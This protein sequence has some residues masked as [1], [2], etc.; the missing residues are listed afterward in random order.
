MISCEYPHSHSTESP[1]ISHSYHHSY[2]IINIITIITI[3]T[4][5][6]TMK[7]ARKPAFLMNSM[8]F[9][10]VPS[11]P[12]EATEPRR[13]RGPPWPPDRCGT[14]GP[15]TSRDIGQS[16]EKTPTNCGNRMGIE[17]EESRDFQY[18][19]WGIVWI[20][21]QDGIILRKSLS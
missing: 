19:S 12:S 5:I 7:T 11:E 4:S 1:F 13:S 2:H 10:H 6:F 18:L 15:R 20:H 8:A 14:P 3:I 21:R 9:P 16:G 17:W